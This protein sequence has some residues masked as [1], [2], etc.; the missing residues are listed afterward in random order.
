[1]RN[2]PVDPGQT[3]IIKESISLIN[4]GEAAINYG[5][6]LPEQVQSKTA[7]NGTLT[8]S[9]NIPFEMVIENIVESFSVEEE[10]ITRFWYDDDKD[11]IITIPLEIN[12]IYEPN[13][14]IINV[15]VEPN[16]FNLQQTINLNDTLFVKEELLIYNLS[17]SEI[18]W[19]VNV[20]F[21]QS[22][23]GKLTG[24]LIDSLNIPIEFS[25][26][27]ITTSFVFE[28]KIET[29]FWY[30]ENNDTTIVI[31]L[32]INIDVVNV[33]IDAD[34]DLPNEITLYQNYPNPFNPSTQISFALPKSEHVQLSVF[35]V[36]GQMIVEL[37]NDQMPAGVHQV[38]FDAQGLSS[39]TYIYQLKTSDGVLN[40]K[41]LLIK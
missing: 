28:D 8:D 2:V 4:Q 24:T 19:E 16:T 11:S 13:D 3:L 39:G 41:L 30:S 10:I 33:S 15:I 12:V 18:N 35:N 26:T 31:P 27:D 21:D 6:L 38:T 29:R 9:L 37:I 17:E 5:V 14:P 20:P 22:N 1:M 23:T 25:I 34:S 7:L 36:S 40:K 32:S